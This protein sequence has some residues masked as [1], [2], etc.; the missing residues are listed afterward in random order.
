MVWGRRRR[1]EGEM[2][3]REGWRRRGRE[4]VVWKTVSL[5]C[6]QRDELTADARD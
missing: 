4:L 2:E 3:G 6:G 1:W 5:I